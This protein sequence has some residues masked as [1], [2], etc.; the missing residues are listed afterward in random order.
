MHRWACYTTYSTISTNM[1]STLGL[2][3]QF[4]AL[5]AQLLSGLNSNKVDHQFRINTCRLR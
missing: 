5:F 3:S 2:S 1:S 4:I